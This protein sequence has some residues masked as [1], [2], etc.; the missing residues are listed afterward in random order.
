MNDQRLKQTDR[1]F[2]AVVV[3]L[4]AIIVILGMIEFVRFFL[5]ASAIALNRI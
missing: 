1:T 3:A 2:H 5:F 4:A